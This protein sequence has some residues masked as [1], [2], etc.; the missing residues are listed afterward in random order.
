MEG[1]SRIEI[2]KLNG[3]KFE[4]WKLKMEYLLRSRV[5]VHCGSQDIFEDWDKL[6]RKVRNTTQLCFAN[7]VLLNV[8]D[9]D[10]AKKLWHKL[11]NLYELKYLVNKLFL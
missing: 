10:I 4:L 3:H 7:L 2:E 1:S 11:G 8:S 6:K 5:I 9:E